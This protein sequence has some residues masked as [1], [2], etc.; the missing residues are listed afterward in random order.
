MLPK[1][2]LTVKVPG[3]L[4]VAGEFSVLEPYYHAVVTAVNRFVYATVENSSTCQLTLENFNLRNLSWT[5]EQNDVHIE[6]ADA[7]TRFVKDAMMIALQYLKEHHVSLQPFSLSIKSNLEDKSGVKY[8]LGSSAAVVTAVISIILRKFLPTYASK[9]TIFKLAAISHMKTQ[10]NGSG[11][12]IA[13]S[14][15]GGIIKYA[16][17]QA[18]WLKEAYKHTMHLTTLV[19]QDWPYLS[20][21]P[22]SFPKQFVHFLV[23]WTGHPASTKSLVDQILALKSENEKMYEQFLSTSKEAVNAFIQGLKKK[24]LSQLVEGIKL[25]RIS[26]AGVG[27]AAQA[28]IETSLLK[29]LCDLAEQANGAGKPAGAG[30]GDCGIAFIPTKEEAIALKEKWKQS[31]IKPLQLSISESGAKIKNHV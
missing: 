19:D 9:R 10:G 1:T 20:I 22:L 17:F 27:K 11:A 26:L 4:M 18:D 13:A 30:G 25:N 6:N 21:E 3:K 5:Y 12:D 29:V 16:S 7:R 24:D 14:T 15:Y 31:G 2:P 28:P 23:G 8:G